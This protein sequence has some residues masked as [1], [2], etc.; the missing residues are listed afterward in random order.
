VSRSSA[1]AFTAAQPADRAL[2]S[3]RA[4]LAASGAA[5]PALE[6][7]CLI[8][9]ACGFDRAVL[10][11][12]G[13]RP[14]GASAQRLNA[15]AARRL[16]GEPLAR[17]L[18]EWEFWGLAFSLSAATL[19]PRPDT[20]TLVEAVLRC[21]D[22]HDGRR[23]PWRILDLGT[24]SGCIAIALLTEL[25][26]ASLVGVDRSPQALMTARRNAERHGVAGRAHWIAGDW[27]SALDA[28]FDIVVSNPPYV[29]SPDIPGLS[30]EVREHDPLMALDGGVDGL[31]CYRKIAGELGRLLAQGGSVF[32]E[33][34]AGQ[35][36]QLRELL[37]AQGLAEIRSHADLA[38]VE[39]VVS[40]VSG[41]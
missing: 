27:A 36:A 5:S 39:R 4:R 11:A 20:E 41:G 28:S 17:I 22:S 1:L 19:V 7:R 26:R 29:A 6:A 10:V 31:A 37:A 15:L 34:G 35:E 13:D 23:H 8:E 3:L 24:G 25:P 21:C 33:I 30:R 40:A 18:G 38:G 16:A 12:H 2:A 32:L 14:L 9:A